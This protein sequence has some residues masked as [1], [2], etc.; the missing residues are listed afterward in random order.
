MDKICVKSITVVNTGGAD[1]IFFETDLPNPIWPYTGN[2]VLRMESATS[3]TDEFL[4]VSFP[5]TPVKKV[6]G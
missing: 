4:I 2:S 6:K 3:K 1:T 5:D